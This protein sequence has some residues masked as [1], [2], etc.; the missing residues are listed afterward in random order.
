LQGKENVPKRI[1]RKRTRDGRISEN[2][3]YVGRPTKHTNHADILLE[4]A[5][6]EEDNMKVL[7]PKIEP[8]KRWDC[9]VRAIQTGVIIETIQGGHPAG[10][11]SDIMM[12]AMVIP[13]EELPDDF[14]EIGRMAA[15]II[16]SLIQDEPYPEWYKDEWLGD[17]W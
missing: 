10:W 3:V 14:S 6:A 16:R 17:E 4:L 12:E 5:S 13:P 2:T 7:D 9:F 11:A 15:E 8:E 1:Q